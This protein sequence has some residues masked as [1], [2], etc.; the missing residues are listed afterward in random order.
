MTVASITLSVPAGRPL[1]GMTFALL[2][3]AVVVLFLL[4]LMIGPVQIPL[5][6]TLAAL[7]G[8]MVERD[9][10]R[11]IIW[12]LR[13]PRAFTTVLAGAALAAAGL[14]MQT[15]FRNPPADPWLLGIVSGA[16]LGVA[17]RRRSSASRAG[18]ARRRRIRPERE[19]HRR[20]DG[21]GGVALAVLIAPSRRVGVATL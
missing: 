19:P 7:T 4:E 9:A 10:W 2:I 15:L 5:R 11:T 1:R 17:L 13:L 14:Q 12:T 18:A 16:R 6:G 8:G 3:V 20:G 21:G